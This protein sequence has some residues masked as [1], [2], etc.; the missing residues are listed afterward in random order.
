MKL[1]EGPQVGVIAQDLKKALPE[2]VYHNDKF[3]AVKYNK[4]IGLLIESI[5]ESELILIPII[6]ADE[7][8]KMYF[9]NF[10]KSLFCL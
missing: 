4:I 6:G 9:K 8:P 5:K 3:L 7:G 1:P 2:A 10:P